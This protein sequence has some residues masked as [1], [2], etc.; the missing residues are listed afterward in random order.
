MVSRA[1]TTFTFA[2][3]GRDRARRAA[4]R[5]SLWSSRVVPP[6]PADV[7]GNYIRG[8][9]VF[10]HAQTPE[11]PFRWQTFPQRAVITPATAHMPKRIRRMERL[12]GLEIRFDVDFDEIIDS[13]RRGRDGKLAWLTDDIVE[14]Y[15]D[16][17]RLG[18]VATI[19]AYRGD[20]AVAGLL[21][22]QVGG[23]LGIMSLFHTEDHSGNLVTLAAVDRLMVGD[24]W[25]IIDTGASLL[26]NYVRFGAVQIPRDE[27]CELVA[28]R[29]LAP[30]ALVT[31]GS[32]PLSTEE[33]S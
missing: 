23:T 26:D 29:L 8:W 5:I 14:L 32:S 33:T 19:G 12:S 1:L 11:M 31:E 22:L 2:L 27:F 28:G 4:L 7:I 9:I 13:C 16:L 10:G 18:Y 17:H 30:T 15:R 21:G 20:V 3:L 6:T 24:R 25:S